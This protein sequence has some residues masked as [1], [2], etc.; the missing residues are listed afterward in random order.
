MSIIIII[1]IFVYDRVAI[2]TFF[3]PF[4]EKKMNKKN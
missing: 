1:I 3:S 2:L 4:R